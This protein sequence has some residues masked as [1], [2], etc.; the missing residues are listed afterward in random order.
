MKKFFNVMA[1]LIALGIVFVGCQM[2][3][4]PD[5]GS[6]SSNETTKTI[7]EKI[8][9]AEGAIDLNGAKADTDIVVKK[10]VKISN[11]DMNGKTLTVDIKNVTLD[12]VTNVNLVAGE[13]IGKG[14]LNIENCEIKSLNVKG[15]GSNSIHLKNTT[16]TTVVVEKEGVR[17]ELGAGC[18]VE[19]VQIKV[20]NVKLESDKAV[21]VKIEISSN[22]KT[23]N[24]A[25]GKVSLKKETGAGTAAPK[26]VFTG[27][28]EI[29]EADETIQISATEEVKETLT[30]PEDIT[31]KIEIEVVTEINKSL[32][33]SNVKTVYEVGQEF[34][35]TNL[36]L[37]TEYSNGTKDSKAVD[38]KDCTVTGFDSTEVGTKKV[39]L[40]VGENSIELSVEIIK[41]AGVLELDMTEAKFWQKAWKDDVRTGDPLWILLDRTAI[42]PDEL[43]TVLADPQDGLKKV[44]I[45]GKFVSATDIN[46]LYAKLYIW[47]ED[48]KSDRFANVS[49]TGSVVVAE[50]V[51]AGVETSYEITFEDVETYNLYIGILCY[52]P[53]TE[54]NN[55]NLLIENGDSVPSRAR[56]INVESD[57][58]GVKITLYPRG[59]FRSGSEP[60]VEI[61]GTPLYVSNY[62]E[63]FDKD[64]TKPVEYV[65]S[66][67]EKDKPYYFC[68]NG[69]VVKAIAG[70]GS[71]LSD[72]INDSQMNVLKSIKATVQYDSEKNM[73]YAGIDS[74]MNNYK[75]ILNIDE[76]YWA[77]LA[78][79]LIMGGTWDVGSW[80]GGNNGTFVQEGKLD[81]VKYEIE[82]NKT[83]THLDALKACKVP[84]TWHDP[85]TSDDW[86]KYK[87]KYADYIV[88]G[89][90]TKANPKTLL[91]M[92]LINSDIMTYTPPASTKNLDV[93]KGLSDAIKNV[94][95]T[96]A[97]LDDLVMLGMEVYTDI[98][99]SMPSGNNSR[100]I[101]TVPENPIKNYVEA[102]EAICDFVT[103]ITKIMKSIPYTSAYKVDFDKTINIG[104]LTFKNWFD[105]ACDI[106]DAQNKA[107]YIDIR[108]DP[109]Y[110]GYGKKY[111][112]ISRQKLGDI[113][114]GWDSITIIDNHNWGYKYYFAKDVKVAKIDTSDMPEG[115]VLNWSYN[116]LSYY[117][118][119]T[120]DRIYLNREIPENVE[121]FISDG[122][123]Y[124]W[125]RK[126]LGVEVPIN[127]D[128]HSTRVTTWY[129]GN[130]R[131]YGIEREERG[132]ETS[133]A[134]KDSLKGFADSLHMTEEEIFDLLD[135]YVTIK[136]FY[137]DADIDIDFDFEKLIDKNVDASELAKKA[138]VNMKALLNTGV[139]NVEEAINEFAPEEISFPV[140]ALSLELQEKINLSTTNEKILNVIY[141]VG[142]DSSEID[143]SS[144]LDTC[145]CGAAAIIKT[146]ICTSEGNGGLITINAD[147]KLTKDQINKIVPLFV[148]S[149]KP[150]EDALMELAGEIATI[151][152]TVT[153]ANNVNTF[154]EEVTIDD[155]L[156]AVSGAFANMQ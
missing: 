37:V 49:K 119:S 15:G 104:E 152:I 156:T 36:L 44:T 22:V 30:V 53:V 110:S 67:T 29:K 97:S 145:D 124:Y 56:Y 34:D 6:N 73:F 140:K 68:Y 151:R 35:V 114:A 99:A 51:K 75:D 3:T 101:V 144:V 121:G 87:Y 130:T 102:S 72:V 38:A 109:Y 94:K 52:V 80:W 116:G 11:L 64:P 81:P 63:A 92:D 4:A 10:P 31:N 47:D 13:G 122:G 7:G 18:K 57:T 28:T 100:S 1:I 83:I 85:T 71:P 98:M 153:N 147:G 146:A 78:P 132:I 39:T 88:F 76:I 91:G 148:S 93:E 134:L 46:K 42:T 66:F 117:N 84:F 58:N 103:D 21:E 40:T 127:V 136:N 23:L 89:F 105:I 131:V 107:L 106:V 27:A 69:E 113:P 135:K 141:S 62:T 90:R 111:I 12:K 118:Y 150:T 123:D 143:F 43:T 60:S 45:K 112:G 17:I 2:N 48:S 79:G 96:P 128:N 154:D 32:D 142:S 120:G 59:E 139:V 14:D 8:N 138:S 54:T 95:N 9:S 155:I 5:S 41:E 19:T 33:A 129:E 25:G 82:G 77:E 125:T 108:E 74:K 26:I 61:F 86:K 126:V 70:G 55:T 115:Y 50:N 24:V 133:E 137:Y 20:D 16:T 65:Y 149:T